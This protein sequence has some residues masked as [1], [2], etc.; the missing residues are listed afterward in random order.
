MR[1]KRLVAPL[2]AGVLLSALFHVCQWFLLESTLKAA[3]SALAPSGAVFVA[4]NL[5]SAVYNALGSLHFLALEEVGIC[6]QGELLF[7]HPAKTSSINCFDH[8]NI[9]K[10][11]SVAHL[12]NL[13]KPTTIYALSN[14]FQVLMADLF[15]LL[16]GTLFS[17][18]AFNFWE[19]RRLASRKL[20]VEA[21]IGRIAGQV[22]HDIRGPI[23]AI[24]I[25]GTAISENSPEAGE[26]IAAA[27]KRLN[28]TT[29]DILSK[30]R[31]LNRKKDQIRIGDI[32]ASVNILAQSK[33][34]NQDTIEI[35]KATKNFVISVE[36]NIF[37]RALWNVVSNS[38]DARK[39]DAPIKI[40]I[41][42]VIRF[43][44]VDIIIRDNGEGVKLNLTQ[45]LFNGIPPSS[46]KG[47]TG[48][49]LVGSREMLRRMGIILKFKSQIGKGTEVRFVIPKNMI[50]PS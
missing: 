41:S 11:L 4:R 29:S 33:K 38:F 48:L 28:D 15:T 49:G 22:A 31:G 36:Q 3:T 2:L 16:F 6:S 32:V 30:F 47:G 46:K 44:F 13:D 23:S 1:A 7:V 27:V 17:V 21:E 26:M 40:V 50:T 19:K 9:L 5:P 35:D 34:H 12:P 10:G 24:G 14:F 25:A 18:L 45:R 43:R 37:E 8:S 39:N 20:E 42:S